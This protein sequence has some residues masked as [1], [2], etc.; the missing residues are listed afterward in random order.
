MIIGFPSIY[1]EVKRKS[2][3]TARISKTQ[4]E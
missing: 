1:C 4:I 3:L 2:F